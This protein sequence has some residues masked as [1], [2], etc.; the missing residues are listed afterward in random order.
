[1]YVLYFVRLT[2]Q[3]VCFCQHRHK[4]MVNASH[5]HSDGYTLSRGPECFGTIVDMGPLLYIWSSID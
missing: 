3:S 1:M 4:Q 2:T 5:S